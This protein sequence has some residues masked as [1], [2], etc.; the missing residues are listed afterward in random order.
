[1]PGMKNRI[2]FYIRKLITK[3]IGD[4][5]NYEEIKKV[6][7][8]AILNYDFIERSANYHHSFVLYDV[9]N[10]VVFND[11]LE[12]HTLEL[13]KLGEADGT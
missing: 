10:Q 1:M 8:I 6:I 7:S 4:G 11:D 2:M 13:S 9:E 3:Q 5:D 12:I